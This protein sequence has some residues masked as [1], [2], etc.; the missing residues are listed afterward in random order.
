MADAGTLAG[1]SP[2]S[3]AAAGIFF[4]SCLMGKGR[5]AKD[6]GEAT[7]VSR[8]RLGMHTKSFMLRGSN[9]L[10]LNG[11]RMERGQMV[12]LPY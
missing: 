4:I 6:V 8:V 10:I 1:R 3:I 2:I 12:W 9:W 11:L 7:G 5:P